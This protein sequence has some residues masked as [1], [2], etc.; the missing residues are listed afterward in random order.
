ME[1]NQT[2]TDNSNYMKRSSTNLGTRNNLSIASDI[3]GLKILEINKKYNSIFINE[4]S[5]NN[6][7]KQEEYY[8]NVINKTKLKRLVT[9]DGNFLTTKAEKIISKLINLKN[10]ALSNNDKEDAVNLDW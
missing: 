2:P 7:K 5:V 8:N 6:L 1:E 10:K 9:K 4:T 3:E